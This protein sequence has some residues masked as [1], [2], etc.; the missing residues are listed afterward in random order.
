MAISFCQLM[1]FFKW[2]IFFGF[3]DHQIFPQHKGQILYYI[4]IKIKILYKKEN[5]AIDPK[6]RRLFEA[7]G[8]KILPKIQNKSAPLYGMQKVGLH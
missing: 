5:P 4:C 2:K 3:S 7:S 8:V 1:I 6:R